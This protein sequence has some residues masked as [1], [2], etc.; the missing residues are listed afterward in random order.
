MKVVC[1]GDFLGNLMIGMENTLYLVWRFVRVKYILT[2]EKFEVNILL[3]H[4]A[5][6]ISPFYLH[7]RI[8][9]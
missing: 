3:D 7:S 2:S 5:Q 4:T 6:M 9:W 8:I 1:N